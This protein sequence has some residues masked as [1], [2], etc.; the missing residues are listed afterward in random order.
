MKIFLMAAG[1]A[2]AISASAFAQDK[3][4]PNAAQPKGDVPIVAPPLVPADPSTPRD[5]AAP[6]GSPT[7]PVIVGGNLT[8]PPLTQQAYPLCTRTLQ[9]QCRNPGWRRES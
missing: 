1:A 2:L 3:P 7:N 9:D 5:P 6:V 4:D 8:P